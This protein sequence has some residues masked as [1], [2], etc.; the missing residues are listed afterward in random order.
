M[1]EDEVQQEP[2]AEA[3]EFDA[4]AE[5]KGLSQQI[6]DRFGW[7]TVFQD[8][9][10]SGQTRTLSQAADT[11]AVGITAL[12]AGATRELEPQVT[13]FVDA[14]G[15]ELQ[16]R[17]GDPASDEFDPQ[18]TVPLVWLHDGGRLAQLRYQV[19]AHVG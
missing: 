15:H 16:T 14:Y 7:Q 9:S 18:A 2:E 8:G 4:Y 3:P 12:Y 13:Q 19:E 1:A 5:A 11:A 10:L 17:R 6:M